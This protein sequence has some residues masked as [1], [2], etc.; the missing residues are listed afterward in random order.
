MNLE[1]LRPTA[2]GAL[3]QVRKDISLVEAEL[4]D[5]VLSK[6]QLVSDVGEHTLAAGG[7]RLRPAFVLLSARA[8]GEQANMDRAIRLAAAL[9]MIHMAT[10][11]HDDVID[12]AATRR[13]RPTAAATFG[14]T[15]SILSGD[16]L[17]SKAM[18]ILAEDGDLEIIRTVSKAVVEMAEGE[19]LELQ[20]RGDFDLA[21]SEHMRILRM[22]TAALVQCCCEVGARIGDANGQAREALK[23]YGHSIGMAFQIVDDVLDLQGETSAT[24]KPRATD[25]REGCMT[26]PMIYLREGLDSAEADFARQ[27][28]GNGVTDE[29]ISTLCNWMSDRGSFSQ[30]MAVAEA[31]VSDALEAIA[32]LGSGADA[33]LL[34]SV[35]EYVLARHQ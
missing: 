5:L 26:L 1:A 21:E 34:S 24:G 19:V 10:L 4:R 14:N 8:A 9:E 31:F 18:A 28:F 3:E 25:F 27:K 7:K 2:S 17:L 30:A 35:A 23:R 15:A 6:I 22:K 16:V 33:E 29:D 20:L 12:H 13:G 11:I 32:P